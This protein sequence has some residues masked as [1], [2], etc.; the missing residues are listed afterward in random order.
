ME[1]RRVKTKLDDMG[2]FAELR[3]AHSGIASTI[4]PEDLDLF[5]GDGLVLATEVRL[6][7]ALLHSVTLSGTAHPSR[8]ES[9]AAT[10]PP[11][12]TSLPGSRTTRC[13]RV[14]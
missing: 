1:G 7:L 6:Y 9:R 5:S 2:D 12:A 3:I 8:S 14:R 11:Y 10:A 13:M 4:A